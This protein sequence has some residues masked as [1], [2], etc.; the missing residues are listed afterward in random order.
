MDLGKPLI[1]PIKP[2]ERPFNYLEYVKFF[3]PN[4]KVRIF[5]ATIRANVEI[6]DADI[7]NLF[8][9]TLKNIIFD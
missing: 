5:K 6:D 2:H 4:V 1:P 8:G 3:D 7:V 9:F